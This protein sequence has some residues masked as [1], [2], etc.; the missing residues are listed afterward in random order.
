V[1]RERLQEGLAQ[2]VLALGKMSPLILVVEDLHW[3]D[4][5]TLETVDRLADALCQ[6][7]TADTAGAVLLIATFRSEEAR[8]RPAVWQALQRMDRRYRCTRL[9]LARLSAEETAELV[10]RG[11]G[12]SRRAP[13]FEARL[14]NETM[15]N[16]LFVVE[17]LRALHDEG[18]L[19]RS[20][21]GEWSTPWDDVTT[22]Y[23]ELPLP[24]KVYE[25]ISRRLGWLG[26]DEREIIETAA[27]LGD[28]QD[29]DLLLKASDLEEEWALAAVSELVQR[30]LL[31]EGPT[32]LH[33]SHDR[34][35]QVVS[36][37]T[38][39]R[40]QARLH[41]RA[42]EALEALRPD[43]LEALAGHFFAAQAWEKALSYSRQA[44]DRARTVYAGAEAMAHYGRA[45]EACR[46]TSVDS[47]HTAIALHQA[48]GETGQETGRFDEAEEDFRS[49]GELA[50]RA[51]DRE[52]QARALNGLSYL[53]FQRGDYR[54]TVRWAQEAL[55]LAEPAQSP[56]QVAQALSNQANA[57]RNLGRPQEAIALYGRAASIFGELNDRARVADCLN[58]SGYA[59]LMR[60]DY[61]QARAV[62]DEGLSIR[63]SLNDRVGISYSLT[64][65]TALYYL[66][67][68]FSE[69]LQA[70]QEALETARSIGDPYGEDAAVLN[71]G[72][73]ALEQ[74]SLEQAIPLFEESVAIA[75]RIGD[76]PAAAEA[77]AELGRAHLQSGF[78]QRAGQLLSEAI[79]VSASTAECWH[80]P[81]ARA[82]LSQ[83][84]LATGDE[85]AA[86]AE[87]QAGLLRAELIG[88][89]WTLGIAHRAVA[90]AMARRGSGQPTTSPRKHFE[91]SIRLLRQIDARAELARSLAAYGRFLACADAVADLRRGSQ[92]LAEARCTFRELGMDWDIADLETLRTEGGQAV[93]ISVRL[94]AASAPTGR[95]LHDD[96]WVAVAWTV[97]SPEDR[98]P[99]GK[100]ARRRQRLLRLL[101]EASEQHAAPTVI[102]LAQALQVSPATIKR[103]LLALRQAGHQPQTRGTRSP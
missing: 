91:E 39:S 37:E 66:Q 58:R 50:Q 31:E 7:P 103:D 19:Y 52:A 27:V 48:R 101:D 70:A 6:R 99:G 79:E 88:D 17:T 32:T 80:E 38:D 97:S 56:L 74:G 89:P 102:D 94:P 53:C 54:E 61:A 98:A 67:G 20:P 63:R 44:G 75:R 90:S 24:N 95:P 15:G 93:Q 35:R 29:L 10:R 73:I 23:A 36:L 5:P 49:A 81:K 76:S 87:A 100:V 92:L 84:L 77:M 21:S 16:P 4:E 68:R 47:A 1:E 8:E 43:E 51:Q 42:G 9:D 72:L 25:V 60:G 86:L 2:V 45:L 40:E 78:P 11:L 62:M 55:D 65:L 3:V 83:A 18:V 14:F 22:D 46:R 28:D 96:E 64:N 57:L 33:F 85:P 71:L 34:V 12:L 30:R 69:M 59:C 26:P 82:Y 13:Y 41:Q